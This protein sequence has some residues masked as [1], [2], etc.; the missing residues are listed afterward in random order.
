MKKR[1]SHK[2]SSFHG[3]EGGI[4]THGTLRH[5]A[6]RERPVQPLLHL[7]SRAELI[8]TEIDPPVKGGGIAED[9]RH[10]GLEHR[11]LF[12]RAQHFLAEYGQFQA[13]Y[14]AGYQR[15]NRE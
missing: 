9:E 4:R 7:S 12:A 6:F 2:R 1:P 8:V 11:R 5:T 15:L 3:G 10:L 13:A 14:S